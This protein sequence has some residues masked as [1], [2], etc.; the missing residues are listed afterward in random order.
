MAKLLDT[1]F[2]KSA[3]S[4]LCLAVLLTASPVSVADVPESQRAEVDYLIRS[5]KTSECRMI[6]NGRL[7]DGEEAAAH[8]QHKYDY[9]REKIS[10][11]RQ[12]IELAATKS[13][14]SGKVYMVECAGENPV[15][16][17]DWLQEKLRIYRGT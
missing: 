11:T 10:S 14:M 7:Y 15:P 17:A 16:S 2:L 8:V 9:Y 4:V 13:T 1:M 5:L 12:F 6:R 3:S